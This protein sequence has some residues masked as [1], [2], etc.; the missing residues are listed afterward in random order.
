MEIVWPKSRAISSPQQAKK[1]NAGADLRSLADTGSSTAYFQ[2]TRYQACF[3]LGADYHSHEIFAARRDSPKPFGYQTTKNGDAVKDIQS[4]LDWVEKQ[5]I[6]MRKIEFIWRRKLR[7]LY[8]PFDRFAEP[9]RIKAVIAEYPLV[10][11]RGNV[12]SKLDWWNRQKSNTAIRRT[13]N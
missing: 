6:W 1:K 5:T 8:R 7:R 9:N 11:I 2:F 3:K 4:L 13:R 12:R 10:S